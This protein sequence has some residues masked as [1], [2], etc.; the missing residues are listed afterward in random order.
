MAC[1]WTHY[2]VAGD[3]PA[4]D[5]FGQ[6]DGEDG[7]S[8][9]SLGELPRAS[10]QPAVMR[11]A[12]RAGQGPLSFGQLHLISVALFGIKLVLIA[13]LAWRAAG[14]RTVPAVAPD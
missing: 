3:V 13:V 11:P 7:S 9:A 14:A 8:C 5:R 4:G 10:P 6:R 1:R 2:L 12:A